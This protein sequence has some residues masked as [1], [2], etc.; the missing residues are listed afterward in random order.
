MVFR[1]STYRSNFQSIITDNPVAP[2]KGPAA[3][4]SENLF[5]DAVCV[6]VGGGVRRTGSALANCGTEK[7]SPPRRCARRDNIPTRFSTSA[8]TATT[9]E[10]CARK[11][12]ADKRSARANLGDFL[13]THRYSSSL[14]RLRAPVPAV[15]D[16]SLRYPS[17][18]RAARRLDLFAARPAHCCRPP[19]DRY[20][21]LCDRRRR[22]RTQLRRDR[23]YNTN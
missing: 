13:I 12:A 5:F 2:Q 1:K 20:P 21:I 15:R 8:T 3:S 6:C 7:P 22:V 23:L 4:L 11:Y 19:N 9:A 17:A 10:R 18:V 16:D 14:R